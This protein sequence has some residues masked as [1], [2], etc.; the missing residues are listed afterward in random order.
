MEWH[1]TG[2]PDGKVDFS[3]FT[4]ADLKEFLRING[5]VRMALTAILPESKKLRGWVEG[6]LIPLVTFYQEG[7]SH[8]SSAD[9]ERVREW[10]KLEFNGTIVEVNGKAVRVAQSTKGKRALAAFAERVLDWMTENYAPPAEALDSEQYKVWR[11][12][13]Y[14]IPGGPDNYLDHLVER[15]ILKANN[16]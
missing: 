2:Q 10:L 7:M 13:I 4:K 14:L 15:G 1:G 16:T 12:T 11:D 3:D 5:P 8:R 6:A 9:C